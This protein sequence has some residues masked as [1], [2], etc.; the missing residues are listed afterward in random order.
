MP[1]PLRHHLVFEVRRSNTCVHIKLHR[2]LHVEEVSVSGVHVDDHGRDLEMHRRRLLIRVAHRHGELELAQSADGAARAVR[3][4]DR[5]VEIHV[6][7][8]EVADG[9]RIAAEVNG[10]KAVV[11]HQLPAHRVVDARGE[12]VR[13]FRQEPAQARTWRLVARR[14]HF[15]A[16]RQER[17]G[18]QFHRRPPLAIRC[19]DR[20]CRDRG[21][22]TR[23]WRARGPGPAIGCPYP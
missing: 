8:P 4:L 5:R 21:T 18:N 17:R 3:D 15:V 10:I 13:F 19:R 1:A 22:R 7:R 11:H 9:E 12:D 16:L 2:A 6:R 23:V 20:S 14:R